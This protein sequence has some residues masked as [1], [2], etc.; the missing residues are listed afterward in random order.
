MNARLLAT[1]VILATM[2]FSAT[3]A[4]SSDLGGS[5]TSLKEPPPPA[6]AWEFTF[7]PY[8]WAIGLSGDVAVRGRR[9]EVDASI[10]DIVEDSNSLMA[11][12]VDAEARNGRFSLY[13]NTVYADLTASGDTHTEKNPLPGLSLTLGADV[14][15][16]FELLILE[17]GATYELFRR[18][19]GGW[20]DPAPTRWTALDLIVGGRYWN[21]EADATLAITG[22][23]NLPALG[24]QRS[25]AL[26]LADGGTVEWFDPLVGLRL[27]H[28]LA[29]GQELFARGD[30]GGFGVGS[31]FTWNATAGYMWECRCKP[32]GA[33]MSGLVGYRALYADYSQGAGNRLIEWDML[34]H[35]PALGAVFR[36]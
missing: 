2:V 10:V 23:V 6:S 9:S 30:I 33:T 21:M 8:G 18:Q 31:D 22:A 5:K 1:I 15:V 27:R 7:I 35:G 24:L 12:M 29:P 32:F 19:S 28:Q 11:F 34:I 16:D 20:K 14:G 25:G 26:A 36:F 3:S 17:G 13:S 4:S